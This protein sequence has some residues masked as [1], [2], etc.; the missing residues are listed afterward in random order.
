MFP[1][2]AIA[3]EIERRYPHC[4]L[5]FV[6]ASDRMEMDKIPAAGYSINGLWISGFQRSFS[7]KNFLFPVKLIFS[8]L[9]SFFIV[10]RFNPDVVIGT[11]GYAS[12]PVLWVASLLRIP[13]LIQEQNSYPGITNKIL[14]S[15]VSKVCGAYLG[16]DRFFPKEKLH[17]TGNPIRAEIEFGVYNRDEVLSSYGL[18]KEKPLVLVVGGS[19]GAK[20]INETV[21][22][23]ISWFKENDVQLIWQTGMLYYDRCKAAQMDLG[24]SGKIQAFITEM[25]PVLAAADVVVSRA[26][27]IALSEFC[28]LGK[29][30]ILVPSPNVAEDHQ[31]KNAQALSENDAAILVE[32]KNIDTEL[33]EAVNGLV[34]DVEMQKKLGANCKKMDKPKAAER[35]VDII[36]EL[37]HD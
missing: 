28:S 16:L 27:A 19:L 9:R 11:G 20:R 33:F 17:I 6:G 32:E 29:A 4:V 14:S 3:K 7:L 22:E 15:K 36:E 2:L 23:N 1:A 5:L 25:G 37:I 26:G 8:V 21:L 34:K 12:G 10:L 24:Q 30:C 18:V 35:I 13:T 31:K